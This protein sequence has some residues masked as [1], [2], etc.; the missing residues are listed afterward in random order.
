MILRELHE[1]ADAG[2]W[3]VEMHPEPPLRRLVT[4]DGS[5][6]VGDIENAV[7]VLNALPLLLDVV[8]AARAASEHFETAADDDECAD[9]LDRALAAL[10]RAE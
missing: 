9:N 7:T 6:S 4:K 5:L 2:P 3:R 10:D 8:D 1:A